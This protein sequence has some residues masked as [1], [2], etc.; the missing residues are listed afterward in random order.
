M[1]QVVL[2]K[3]LDFTAQSGHDRDVKKIISRKN[4]EKEWF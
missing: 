1:H 4:N 3:R 2:K